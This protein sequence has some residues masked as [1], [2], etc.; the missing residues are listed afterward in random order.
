MLYIRGEKNPQ[1]IELQPERGALKIRTPPIFAVAHTVAA[2]ALQ[3]D[4]FVRTGGEGDEVSAVLWSTAIAG[5]ATVPTYTSIVFDRSSSMG[6]GYRQRSDPTASVDDDSKGD[7]GAAGVGPA[8]AAG[9]LPPPT[10][11]GDAAPPPPGAAAPLGAAALDR[12]AMPP[13]PPLPPRLLSLSRAPAGDPDEA[14]VLPPEGRLDSGDEAGDDTDDPDASPPPPPSL[15]RQEAR[16]PSKPLPRARGRKNPLAQALPFPPAAPAPLSRMTSACPGPGF[17]L[18][19]S[20]MPSYA[21]AAYPEAPQSGPS[22]ATTLRKA[23]REVITRSANANQLRV[24]SGEEPLEFI[25][26]VAF[27]STVDVVIP[28]AD[29][30]ENRFKALL[31]KDLTP[32]FWRRF[33]VFTRPR[34]S[35]DITLGLECGLLGFPE[36]K[37]AVPAG[38]EW[39]CLLTTD[40][41]HNTGVDCSPITTAARWGKDLRREFITALPLGDAGDYDMSFL[42]QVAHQVFPSQNSRETTDQMVGVAYHATVKIGN[43]AV[44]RIPVTLPVKYPTTSTEGETQELK[45]G[46]LYAT[47]MLPL[48]FDLTAAP[49]RTHRLRLT[50]INKEGETIDELIELRFTREEGEGTMAEAVTLYHRTNERHLELRTQ[51]PPPPANEL[52]RELVTME[53]W[54]KTYVPKDPELPVWKRFQELFFIL[55][56]RVSSSVRLSRQ[57]DYAHE[58]EVSEG[59]IASQGRQ[60]SSG[61]TPVLSRSASDDSARQVTETLS[62]GPPHVPLSTVADVE[63]EGDS[64]AEPE[65]PV[66]GGEGDS[67]AEADPP[68][69]GGE[70]TPAGPDSPA[71]PLARQ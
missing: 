29:S 38:T 43:D 18:T 61:Y 26:M 41:E 64:E 70:V 10:K 6:I 30:A 67:E 62:G 21:G 57:D 34:G 12:A 16:G 4:G 60:M 71:P 39:S 20:A 2:M 45:L 65:P 59:I 50:Y 15:R 44:L 9:A 69:A 54:L 33:E 58:Y 47:Q 3:A 25:R 7:D 48:V 56:D 51:T 27:C 52:E 49:T 68:A 40:G 53:G 37:D 17:D 23:V 11:P 31:P 35:T 1:K 14:P 19:C 13:P 8:A 28:E 46:T 24:T 22:R 55:L 5:A 32:E 36:H 42:E 66:V 63:D